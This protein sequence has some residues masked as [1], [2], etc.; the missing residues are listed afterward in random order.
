VIEFLPIPPD[1]VVTIYSGVDESFHRLASAG[2]RTALGRRYALPP[3]FFLYSGAIYP[4]KNFTRLVQAY[5]KVGPALGIHLVIAG[6]ENRFLSEHELEVPEQLGL[7]DWVRWLGWVDPALLPTLYQMADVLL[8]PSLFE[9][10]GLPIVEAMAS[11]CPVLTSDRYGTKEIAGE[12]A[13]LVNPE[14][15]DAIAAGMARLANDPELRARLI[16][17]GRAR[18]KPLTWERCASDTLRTLEQIAANPRR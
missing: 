9:S 8:L 4:P 1:R 13:L 7:E 17:A 16:E 5:A 3:R 18:V 11:G 6:G 2:E 12:A 10:Y 15:V 14:S